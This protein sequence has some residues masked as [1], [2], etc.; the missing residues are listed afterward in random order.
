MLATEHTSRL[1]ANLAA[2]ARAAD[3]AMVAAEALAADGRAGEGARWLPGIKQS[4]ERIRLECAQTRFSAREL[5][6]ALPS[7]EALQPRLW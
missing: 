2:I 3:E 1:L 7:P 4:L 5:R 6:Q